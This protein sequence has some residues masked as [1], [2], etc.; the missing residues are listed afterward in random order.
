MI[1]FC[2]TKKK[3]RNTKI[4]RQKNLQKKNKEHPLCVKNSKEKKNKKIKQRQSTICLTSLKVIK[5]KEEENKLG[6]RAHMFLKK[7]IAFSFIRI[8]TI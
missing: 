4:A 5:Q 8:H 2:I 3:Q 1:G 7:I 6:H